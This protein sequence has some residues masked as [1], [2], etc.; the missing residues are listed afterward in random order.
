[1]LANN[2]TS[3]SLLKIFMA[4]IIATGSLVS[5]PSWAS[6]SPSTGGLCDQIITNASKQANISAINMLNAM[7]KRA[8][9]KVDMAQHYQAPLK[10]QISTNANGILS[11]ALMK[12]APPLQGLDNPFMPLIQQLFG[13]LTSGGGQFTPGSSGPTGGAGGMN[14]G[15]QVVGSPGPTQGCPEKSGQGAPAWRKV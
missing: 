8:N 6:V 5:L 15:T 10:H 14:D 1:M 9:L 3:P 13:Q 4:T 7:H 12:A 11:D 2:K